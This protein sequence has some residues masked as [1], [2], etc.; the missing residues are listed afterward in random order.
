MLIE[1]QYCKWNCDAL[2]SFNADNNNRSA[3]SL[4]SS[5]LQSR[6]SIV[7]PV[8][9][10]ILHTI[11]M[12]LCQ[13]GPII[14]NI[15][16]IIRGG[17]SIATRVSPLP[18]VRASCTA[19]DYVPPR[20][21]SA[22]WLISPTNCQ[23][24]PADYYNNR[25]RVILASLVPYIAHTTTKIRRLINAT[26]LLPRPNNIVRGALCCVLIVS[27]AL[28]ISVRMIF[29]VD[30]PRQISLQT[31]L[32]ILMSECSWYKCI[33]ERPAGI[34]PWTWSEPPNEQTFLLGLCPKTTHSG[35]E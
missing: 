15:I 2:I 28:L 11:P 7:I 34:F 16:I 26:H 35:S 25:N 5:Q 8:I 33:K 22:Q 27:L 24:N 19:V 6:R 17:E 32:I 4:S 30:F 20:C 13:L 10:S 18:P 29:N 23:H 14:I 12:W 9:R 31:I 1:V 21:C 3:S